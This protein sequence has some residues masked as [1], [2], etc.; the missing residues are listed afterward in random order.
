M[1]YRNLGRAGVKVSAV[2]VGC[3]QFG[4]V[5]DREGT[6][7]IVHRALDLGINFFDTADSYG[8]R[9]ASEE[10]LGHALAGQW[11]EVVVATKVQSTMGD[12]PNDGG[13]SRY[14]I[15]YG[16]EASLRRLNTDHIDLYQIHNFDP[17]TPLDETLRALDD[18]VRAGKVRYVGASNFMAWQLARAN[19]LAEMM[20]WASFVSIQ[21]HYHM[22]ER[23]IER[24]LIPYC[25]F[26]GVGILPYFP[27]AGGFLSGKYERGQA[28]APDTRGARSSYVQK[29]LTDA[30]FDLLDHL[31]PL[32]HAHG[33]GLA[34]L[35]I[36][37]LLAQ[38]QIASVI[39]G[40]TR[41]EQ[42]EANSRAADWVLTADELQHIRS[43]LEKR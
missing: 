30:N 39:A 27:L 38:P 37:W 28:P 23:H 22:L 21:P 29:Y 18:L 5:V 4:G 6:R 12:G 13:A 26:A 31:R 25:Q 1:Q 8:N 33:R 10:F 15:Q 41:P 3:N 32:A 2:G 9:G 40:A 19:D 11:Q 42:V 16:V 7:A 20:G 34:D 43:L 14:H 35:A 24:E 17:G 36:A